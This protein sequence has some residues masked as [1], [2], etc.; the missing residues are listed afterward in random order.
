MTRTALG[1][2]L[3]FYYKVSSE[4]G[5]DLF[6]FYIDSNTPVFT[7]SGT[8]IWTQY[9]T[10]LSAGTHT[11]KWQYTKDAS[12]NGGAATVWI[13]DLTLNGDATSWTDIIALTPVGATSTP[14]T[15]SVVSSINK[16]RARTYF[17]SGSYSSWDDS[18]AVFSVVAATQGACCATDGSCTVTTQAGCTGTWQGAATTCTPNPCPQPQGACCAGNGSCTVTTQALCTGTYQGNGTTCTPNPCP[19]AGCAGDVNCDGRVTFTDIDLF[20]EALSGESAWTHTC[21]W[22]NADCN[23]DLH[24]TFADIDPFVGLIGTTC[25]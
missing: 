16:V 5:A 2:S 14:W 7:K 6:T 15:P 4:G 8:I 3:S 10:T 19:P 1:G 24:V 12:V 22:I 23:G 25:P 21:P 9:T 18:D 11:L 17:G 13:D 20:V